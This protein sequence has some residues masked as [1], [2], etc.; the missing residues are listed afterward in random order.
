[1]GTGSANGNETYRFEVSTL[2]DST[3]EQDGMTQ[4]QVV[5]FMNEGS[6]Q[7][8]PMMGYSTDDLA[9][10]APTGLLAVQ[11]GTSITLTWDPL[12]AN[13]F[14]Y[15]SIYRSESAEFETG[16]DNLI[17]YSTELTYVDT[18]AEWFTTLYYRVSATD[19]AG[20]TGPASDAAE[21][22]IHVNFA[23]VMSEI[24]AQSMDEDQSFEMV[25][26]GTDENEAD[27]LTYGALSSEDDV[28][29]TV[30]ND[31]LSIGLTENWFGTAEMMVYVTDGELSDT[32]S[33]TL[34]VNAVNDAPG[35]FGL[36]SP[37]DSTQIT[38]TSA[39][40]MQEIDLVVSWEQSTDVDNDDLSYSFVLYNGTYMPDAAVLIDTL[41]SET[42]LNIPYQSIAELI[43]FMGL[44][45][46]SGDWTVFATDGVDTTLSS[47]IWNIT[48]DASDVLS[49]DGEVL[50]TVF[51]LHQNYPN[52]FNPTT[53]IRYDLPEDANVNITIY[54]IMGRSIRSL[55]NSQQTAGYRSIQWN[56]TNNFGEP[57][58]AG[59]YIYMIQAGEFRQ[60]RKMVLLK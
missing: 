56:A 22:Y 58:S 42:V 33:F 4:F 53:Q 10:E 26:S 18:T 47:D 35:V 46:I 25:V 27:M 13:D 12:E 8:E 36:I 31:T 54:D 6:F 30:S 60:V 15:F 49:V 14:N 9:P 40:L 11:T 59:M 21:G 39:D 41:L 5:A 55:I 37:E 29:A 44:T 2:V 50:P 52:P 20:N 28:M 43:G 1:V 38:I 16:A 32:T 7:S 19:F 57:V 48:L 24:E 23:P 34:T 17:G 3:G 51:A 45:S